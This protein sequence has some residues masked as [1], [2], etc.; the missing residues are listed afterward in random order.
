MAEKVSH[1]S[2]ELFAQDFRRQN[3]LGSFEP[4][5][6]KVLLKKADIQTVYKP[7]SDN[8]SG[9][10][11]KIEDVE[12]VYR[13]MMINCDHPIGKQH[14]TICHEIYHLYYQKEF[15]TAF[16]CTGLF[17]KKG[18]PEEY[19]ADIFASYL[20]LP[21]M[22]VWEQI[23]ESERSKNKISI[24]TI[25]TIEH[26]F[27]CSHTALLFRLLNLGLIDAVY[28]ESLS[29]GV[30]SMA[31]KLGY[32]THLYEKGNENEVI[33]DY[34]L[35]AY[36]AWEHGIVSESS[37]MGLLKDLGIDISKL[38]EEFSNGEL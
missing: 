36:K 33:G 27:G 20:L 13:F 4:L 14:F 31:R 18:N 29:K 2:L 12:K 19:H 32:K 24:E 16:S 10:S 9:M 1:K 34:G 30:V 38:D 21:E 17:D 5:A 8:F 15:K 28:Q 22:G 11:I 23:P 35:L 3:G 25:L 7:L 6:L 37:Y 26:Y